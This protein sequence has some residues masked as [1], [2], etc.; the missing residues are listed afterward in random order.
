MGIC[1]DGVGHVE[2]D[3][4]TDLRDIDAVGRDVRRDQ[5]IEL[6]TREP[7]HCPLS[8]ILRQVPV[9]LS[10]AEFAHLKLLG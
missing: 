6:I 7:L 10:Y 2:I 3:H 1:L 9:K 8:A 4:V 5:Q